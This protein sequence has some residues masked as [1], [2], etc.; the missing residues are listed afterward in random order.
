MGGS[1]DISLFLLVGW[2]GSLDL[3]SSIFL[4]VYWRNKAEDFGLCKLG[5][6]PSVINKCEDQ[7]D[8]G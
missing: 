2:L 8:M 6:V 5:L 1:L 7:E 3:D 4:C